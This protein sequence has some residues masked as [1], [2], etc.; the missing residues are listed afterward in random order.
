MLIVNSGNTT[1][2]GHAIIRVSKDIL[3][4]NGSSNIELI[5]CQSTL[6]FKC[7]LM[8]GASELVKC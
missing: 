4:R 5:F 8:H 2:H 1:C 7:V 6:T 3:K